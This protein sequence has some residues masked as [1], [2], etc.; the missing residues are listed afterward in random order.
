LRR[1]GQGIIVARTLIS[2]I[3]ESTGQ[4]R[5]T[6]TGAALGGGL[7]ALTGGASGRRHPCQEASAAAP[8]GVPA[9]LLPTNPWDGPGIPA[10]DTI[11]GPARAPIMISS[12]AI[13][14]GTTTVINPR[15]R[16]ITTAVLILPRDIGPIRCM[17][18]RKAGITHF[19]PAPQCLELGELSAR[20]RQGKSGAFRLPGDPGC[21]RA[22]ITLL[23]RYGGRRRTGA[24]LI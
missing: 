1:Q 20:K 14:L 6:A 16:I 15:R 24:R 8:S 19:R 3:M 11:T 5:Y 2:L 13:G 7:W 21:P 23:Q 9:A 18:R 12:M 10:K 17:R 4:S 22:C